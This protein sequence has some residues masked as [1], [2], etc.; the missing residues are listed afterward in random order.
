MLDR[1]L[2]GHVRDAMHAI[3]IALSLSTP[4]FALPRAQGHLPPL[5]H[6]LQR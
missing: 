5:R 2:K 1:N 4:P 6:L 3:V